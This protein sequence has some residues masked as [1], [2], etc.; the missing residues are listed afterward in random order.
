M[1]PPHPVNGRRAGEVGALPSKHDYMSDDFR[2]MLGR[3]YQRDY[4][5]PQII[6]FGKKPVQWATKFVFTDL[7]VA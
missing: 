5:E 2:R 1:M 4:D 6:D 7:Y 3:A